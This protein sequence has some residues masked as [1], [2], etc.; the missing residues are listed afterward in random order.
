MKW[1][2]NIEK[3][4]K[5][6]PPGIDFTKQWTRCLIGI[7]AAFGWSWS[8]LVKYL[9]VRGELFERTL[10]GLA[11][12]KGAMMREFWWL[13]HEDMDSL[14]GF[15]VFYLVMLG[16]IVYHYLYYYQGSKAIYLMRRLPDKWEMHRRNVTLPLAAIMIGLLTEV[17]VLLVYY[18]IYVICTP[19]Q[20]LPY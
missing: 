7:S 20:C 8:F 15:L 2:V 6:T 3:M 1:K 11:V 18:G 10:T 19:M 14:D 17:V 4:Q 13:I 12:R 5:Y 16:M 9:T